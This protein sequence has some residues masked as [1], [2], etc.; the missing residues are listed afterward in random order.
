[1]NEMILFT[2]R[3][4]LKEVLARK[5]L[6]IFL[7][8]MSA[9]TF[10]GIAWRWPQVFTSS[11]TILIEDKKIIAP[12]MKGTAQTSVLTEPLKLAKI[13]M[14][15]RTTL[16]EVLKVGEWINKKS[17]QFEIDKLID[18]LR[19]RTKI[20]NTGKKII[21]IHFRDQ[22]PKRAMLATKTMSDIFI[23]ESIA[24]KRKDSQNAYNF[25]NSQAQIYHKKYTNVEKSIKLFRERN[26]DSTPGAM[27]SSNE[28]ILSLSREI[29]NLELEITGE[30]S[31]L[32]AQEAQLLGGAGAENAAS[33]ER[34]T[35]LRIRMNI[36]NDQLENLRLIYED[37]YP[38]IIQIKEQ[39]NAL[40]KKISKEIYQRNSKKTRKKQALSDSPLRQELR[41]EQLKTKARISTHQSRKK[42][43]IGLLHKERNK[44]NRINAVDVEIKELTLE[45]QLNKA[46]YNTLVEQRENARISRDMD[47]ANQGI[48]ARIQESAFLPATPRGIRFLHIILLGFLFSFAFPIG[49]VLGLSLLDQKIRDPNV[50][51]SQ[52]QLPILASV[53]PILSD[54]QMRKKRKALW[55]LIFIVLLVSF[56][57]SVEVWLKLGGIV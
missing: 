53:F 18:E 54:T 33:S 48:N 8:L 7:Y 13:M 27:R 35:T 37:T 6:V 19:S 26:I 42:Q 45:S 11:A 31:K 41:S 50:L 24:I 16:I 55:S 44:I 14:S 10:A 28:R 29:E 39:I 2:F 17:T 1:M 5:K 57:Y 49:V 12:L 36:L 32:K 3:L 47:L 20:S 21:H 56:I 34:V 25:I 9:L 46:R 23:R 22:D 52:L 38:D 15:S 43:L 40:V 30:K 51:S 4:T